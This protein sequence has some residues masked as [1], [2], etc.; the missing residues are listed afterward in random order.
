MARYRR[1]FA[2]GLICSV[3][4]TAI[5]LAAP[6]VL[7]AAIDDLTTGVTRTKLLLYGGGLLAIG[8]VGGVFRFWTR[9]ILIGASR[10][11]EYDMRND[12]FA[13]LQTLPLSYFQATPHRRPD[14]ARDQRSQRRADDD[15]P[16][17]HVL[18]QHAADLR[19]G[20]GDDA[21]DR[22]AADA[23][24]A[25]PAAVRL[26]LGEATSAAPSTRRF[27][28]IQAQLSEVSAVAQ[29]SLSGRARGSRLPAGG[30]RARTFPPGEPGVRAAQPQPDR[31]AGLLLPEHVVL[32]RARV[33]A[34]ALAGQPRG[35]HASA[36]R[37]ASSSPS[38]P[39]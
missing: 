13:H 9:R 17:G 36:S 32:S 8:L 27:E 26:D 24:V 11:I 19:R 16:V 12:F 34:G 22:R 4:T 18:R 37:S 5:T 28:R 1:A 21:G 29:E 6:L 30:G 38:S 2:L 31:A 23:A 15:R 39:T 35:D 10:D 7:R 14:V 33:D 20:A 25:H 3:S